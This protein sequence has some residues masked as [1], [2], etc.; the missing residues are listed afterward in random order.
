M[1][2]R[3]VF[4]LLIT[5]FL[6]LSAYNRDQVSRYA[7]RYTRLTEGKDYAVNIPPDSMFF[8]VNP[9]IISLEGGSGYHPDADCAHFVSQCLQAGGIPMYEN[10]YSDN[11]NYLGCVGCKGLNNFSDNFADSLGMTFHDDFWLTEVIDPVF[12]NEHFTT[13]NYDMFFYVVGAEKV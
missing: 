7:H 4:I 2:T 11:V 13:T 12:E 8:N 6:F 5:S 10:N 3:I 1:K 9:F